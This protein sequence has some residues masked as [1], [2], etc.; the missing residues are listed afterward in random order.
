MAIY[1]TSAE[2]ALE[3]LLNSQ[4]ITTTLTVIQNGKSLKVDT[5]AL[6]KVDRRIADAI[7]K[8]IGTKKAA[9]AV[10]L[11]ANVKI[12][13]K[14]TY[15]GGTAAAIDKK[16]Q[17][18]KAGRAIDAKGRYFEYLVFKKIENYY[19]LL[20]ASDQIEDVQGYDQ[21][22][23]QKKYASVIKDVGLDAAL[24]GCAEKA[25]QWVKKKYPDVQALRQGILQALAQSNTQGDIS[26]FG[27]TLELKTTS[28]WG[29]NSSIKYFELKDYDNFGYGLI[30]YV[31]N[32][33]SHKAGMWRTKNKTL[34][35]DEWVGN[36]STAG[37][38]QYLKEYLKKRQDNITFLNYLLQ[39][40]V[41]GALN[42]AKSVPNKTMVVGVTQNG[43]GNFTVIIDFDTLIQNLKAQEIKE[44][45][46]E[47]WSNPGGTYYL[48]WN[49][50]GKNKPIIT[51]NPE[52][53]DIQGFAMKDGG[54]DPEYKMGGNEVTFILRLN[55]A[56][57]E[58]SRQ[59]GA[60]T[61][62]K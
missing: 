59:L 33:M 14:I 29:P 60:R 54:G 11:L 47:E 2:K 30:S 24:E 43:G 51:F 50:N 34:T 39:K 20:G 18:L 26:A 55:H 23:S 6:S 7:N 17:N 28:N 37:F 38:Q 4:E 22:M 45:I 9:S 44:E 8:A 5:S 31:H 21:M 52:R 10:K 58:L 19:R 25:F 41:G 3:Q 49:D 40:G 1:N 16:A 48:K 57:F 15:A 56:F 36:V 12:D 46:N 35:E 61:D 53:G 62:F 13:S 42:A 32:V 27:I